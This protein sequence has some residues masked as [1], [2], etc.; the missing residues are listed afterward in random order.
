MSMSF[1]YEAEDDSK[2]FFLATGHILL[3]LLLFLGFLL[4]FFFR[5]LA[6]LLLC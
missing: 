5:L 6:M 3:L 2:G 4:P 1:E